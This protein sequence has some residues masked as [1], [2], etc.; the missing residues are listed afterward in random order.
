[1]FDAANRTG[2][3]LKS[4]NLLLCQPVFGKIRRTKIYKKMINGVPL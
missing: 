2:Y 1:M 3:L 4:A